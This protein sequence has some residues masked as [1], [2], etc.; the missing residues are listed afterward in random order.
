LLLVLSNG[1]YD[2]SKETADKIKSAVREG[3]PCVDVELDIFDEANPSPTFLAVAQ[4][5]AIVDYR[6]PD[7]L[8]N[9]IAAGKVRS[10]T[11]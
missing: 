3:A 8:I 4:V 11:R 7:S 1:N 10:L 2:I 6:R 9:A 5:V